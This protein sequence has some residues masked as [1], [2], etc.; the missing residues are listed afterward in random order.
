MSPCCI[1]KDDKRVRLEMW[2][3]SIS[4]KNFWFQICSSTYTRPIKTFGE[5]VLYKKRNPQFSGSTENHIQPKLWGA[6]VYKKKEN[7]VPK[8]FEFEKKLFN[9]TH[10]TNNYFREFRFSKHKKTYINEKVSRKCNFFY[11]F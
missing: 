2:F 3:V 5:Q 1:P 11:I 9:W 4:D 6:L 8:S 7:H 10:Q